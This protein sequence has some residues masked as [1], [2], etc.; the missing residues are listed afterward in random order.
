MGKIF[1]EL[2]ASLL[3]Q[4]HVWVVFMNWCFQP[5]RVQHIDLVVERF[6]G[7]VLRKLISVSKEH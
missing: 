2:L 3:K 4:G 5:Q 6:L 1:K 7:F